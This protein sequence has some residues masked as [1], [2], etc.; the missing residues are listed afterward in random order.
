MNKKI[1]RATVRGKILL[2][3]EHVVVYGQPAIVAGIDRE[4][5]VTVESSE[6]GFLVVS[7][8]RDGL[9][10][11]EESL[12]RLNIDPETVRVTIESTLPVGSGMGSSA[13]LCAGIIKAGADYIERQLTDREW[14]E[15]AWKAEKKAHGNSSGVDP[16]AAV[17]G[18]LL[19][20][21]RGSELEHLKL[22][23]TYSLLLVQTGKP[24]EST[25]EMVAGLS[26]R[27]KK[28][29]TRCKQLF[30]RIGKVTRQIRVALEQSTS[31]KDLVDENGRLLEELGVVG[32][33]AKILSETLRRK[34][35]GVKI[36]GAGGVKKGSGMMIVMHDELDT[37]HKELLAGDYP[38]YPITVGGV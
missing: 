38:V 4:M 22:K 12:R 28:Q 16:A 6:Q 25:G 33:K 24:K 13:A 2:S 7:Q 31:I 8:H 37:I 19:W 9:G 11:V 20:Y 14:F 30:T 32:E 5:V 36:A 26:S 35:C 17:Y 18:G 27:Y 29:E 3:G 1:T 34:G 23:T 10:L 15:L 21:V